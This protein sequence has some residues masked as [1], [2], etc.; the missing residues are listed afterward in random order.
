M[1]IHGKRLSE[2]TK[3][4]ILS[5][6]KEGV[7]EDAFLEFKQVVLDPRKPPEKLD[8]ERDDLVADFVAFANAQRGHLIVGVETDTHERATALVPM[9]GDQAKRVA[10]SLRDLAIAH[11]KPP[12]S[13]EVLD[14]QI[15]EHGSEWL[16][17]TRIPE[18]EN[19]PHMSAYGDRTRFTIRTGNR[20]RE[21][22]Y[23]E[24]SRLFSAAPQQ[25]LMARLLAELRGIK[26]LVEDLSTKFPT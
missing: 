25:D 15:D 1:S 12:I 14:F 10:T 24:I 22:A 16:V 26:S 9:T 19:K 11:I 2:V 17:I 5:L 18:S 4:D 20:N 6:I 13:Q 8:K 7:P 3:G 23:D 21:M